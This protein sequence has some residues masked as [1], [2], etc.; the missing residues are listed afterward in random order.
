VTR[1][2]LE[3]LDDVVR[4]TAD[5]WSLLDGATVLL[6]GATGFVGTWV[7]EALS[8]ARTVSGCRVAAGVMQ[9]PCRWASSRFRP[10]GYEGESMSRDQRQPRV[11]KPHLK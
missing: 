6:T 10:V 2:P 5:V 7:L 3:D 8:H 11:S 9:T 1:T 4:Q